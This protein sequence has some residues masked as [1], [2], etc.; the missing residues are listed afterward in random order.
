MLKALYSCAIRT[1]CST[2]TVL[3]QDNLR[4]F[5]A[6][7]YMSWNK[8]F[9][10]NFFGPKY[11]TVLFFTIFPSLTPLQRRPSYL[12]RDGSLGM[13]GSTWVDLQELFKTLCREWF[14]QCRYLYFNIIDFTDFQ[15]HIVPSHAPP[16]L[17][18][19]AEMEMFTMTWMEI[20]P[21]H[22]LTGWN[23]NR[24]VGNPSTEKI[25]KN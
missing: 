19:D 25:L 20:Q 16:L 10:C 12:D 8:H 5:G 2:R 18:Y 22:K 15:F 21:C 4:C 14:P 6:K 17:P 9:L 13:M 7:W 24:L 3:F 23:S 11:L 1:Y